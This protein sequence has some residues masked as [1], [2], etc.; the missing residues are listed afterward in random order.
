MFHKKNIM[1]VSQLNSYLK[2]LLQGDSLLSNIW[3]KGE[4]SNLKIHSSGHIYFSLKDESSTLRCIM[5]RSYSRNLQFKPTHGLKVL[6]AGYVSIFEQGGMYQ[7]Y[8]QEILPHGTGSLNLAYEQL[9]EKLSAEGLFAKNKRKLPFLPETVGIVTSLSGAA[10]KD[11]VSIIKRRSPQTKIIISPAT[12]QGLEGPPSICSALN[13]LYS[14]KIDVIIIGRGGGAL[15]DLWSFNDEHVVRKIAESPVP[16]ISAVGHET[17]FTLADFVAD[18]RAA[19]PSM[20]AELVVPLNRELKDNLH[21]LKIR[22]INSISDNLLKEKQKINYLQQ[23]YL[24]QSPLNNIF[25]QRQ[26]LDTLSY[27]LVNFMKNKLKDTQKQQSIFCQKLDGLSPLK[28]IARG[29]SI[30][31]NDKN[32][33]IRSIN[34]VEQK[35]NIAVL[36]IDGKLTC[37]VIEK[38]GGSYGEF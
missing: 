10:L 9:K 23:I 19:T 2:N 31:L 38:E 8:V 18:V 5:F 20:A 14:A 34:Q 25:N 28:V 15:E 37:K 21:N 24:R 13:K 6:A 36:L 17:D 1:N 4:I 29:Y 22:L 33:Y 12:V 16:I 35:E 30:C 27:K 32:Q 3:V 7:L 26:Y 11:M